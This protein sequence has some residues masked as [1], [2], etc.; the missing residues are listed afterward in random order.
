MHSVVVTLQD[1]ASL[2][3]FEQMRADFLA[4]VGH[5]LRAPLS[6]IKGSAATLVQS[7]VALEPAAASQFHRI[8]EQ[9]ADYMQ[10]LITD[11]LDVARIEAGTL[12]ITPQPIGVEELVEDAR[13]TFLTAHAGSDIRVELPA[14]LPPVMAERRRI[15]QVLLN[16]LSNAVRHSP[17]DSAVQVSARPS[18]VEVEIQV[19]DRGE[20]IVPERLPKLFNKFSRSL[21]EPRAES[22]ESGLGLAI[23]KG[24][25]EAHGGR[26]RAERRRPP[27]KALS[28]AS[29]CRRARRP[30]FWSPARRPRLGRGRNQPSVGVRASSPWPTIRRPFCMCGTR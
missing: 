17:D 4:M 18:G 16:L 9:Q 29:P 24:I 20:G 25:V 30:P 19:T 8:I 26:I 14:E 13:S 2:Q 15:I 12:A 28:S 5:E 3:Q 6:S 22:A 27:G 23:C 1:L 7:G 21:G 10:D 11:L